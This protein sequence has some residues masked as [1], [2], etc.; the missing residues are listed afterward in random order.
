M[1]WRPIQIME[2]NWYL[3]KAHNWKSSGSD[4]IRNYWL[5]AFPSTHRHIAK[6]FNAIIEEPE[7]AP[8]WLTT[9]ITYLIPKLRE[10][11]V[12]NYRPITCLTTMYKTLTRFSTKDSYTWNITHNSESTAV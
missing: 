4:Q 9:G 11:E 3:S 5:K 7:K 10:H 1:N 8:D 12:R 6:I 2:I